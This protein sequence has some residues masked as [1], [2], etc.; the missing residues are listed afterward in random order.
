MDSQVKSFRALGIFVHM[1]ETKRLAEKKESKHNEQKKVGAG[2]EKEVEKV[3]TTAPR[4]E[5]NRAMVFRAK[6]TVVK[7]G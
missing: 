4:S 1:I 2:T 3:D 7:G 6:D 5:I